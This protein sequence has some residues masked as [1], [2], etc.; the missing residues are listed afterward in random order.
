[1]G[2]VT[3]EIEITALFIIDPLQRFHLRRR[4]TW[5]RIRAVPEA[6]VSKECHISQILGIEN[7]QRVE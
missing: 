4:Q 3:Y 5:D 1:M 6:N 2:D 7:D